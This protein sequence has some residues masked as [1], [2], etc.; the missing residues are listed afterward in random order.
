MSI[1]TTNIAINNG[2]LFDIYHLKDRMILWIKAEDTDVVRRLEYPW[3][4]FIY[5]ISDI[6]SELDLLLKDN[7]LISYFVK[8]YSY[9][10]KYEYPSSDQK[11]KEVLKLTVKDSSQI[12]NLAKYIEWLSSR[13]GQY[14][15]YNVDVSPEQSFFYEKEFFP[16]GLYSSYKSQIVN[17]LDS[18]CLE[19]NIENDSI[20]SFDYSIPNFRFLTFDII[21]DKKSISN[22]IQNEISAI[23]LKAFDNDK[24]LNEKFIIKEDNEIETILQFSYEVNRLDPDI[25]LT[26]GGDQ[27]LFPHLFNRAIKNEIEIQLLINL[28]RELNQEF[29]KIVRK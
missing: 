1:T 14:R 23:K 22:E 21:S 4:P 7:N 15:L 10:Y 5:V 8:N 24:T 19:I 12:S 29:L 26:T 6:K 2:C 3:S 16:F 25:V 13:F 18:S 17:D 9:E 11:K 20:D 28:N 27:F